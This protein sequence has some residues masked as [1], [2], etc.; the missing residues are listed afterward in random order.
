MCPGCISGPATGE[1]V[2]DCTE[3]VETTTVEVSTEP[4][5]TTGDGCDVFSATA[6]DIDESNNIDTV[7]N[8]S[9]GTCQ[10]RKV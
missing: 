8:I 7:Y 5:T 4:P 2:D 3:S 9:V 10:V 1:D 6:C